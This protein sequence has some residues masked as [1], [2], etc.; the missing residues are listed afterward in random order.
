[1]TMKII[2]EMST[3]NIF[4]PCKTFQRQINRFYNANWNNILPIRH[5]TQG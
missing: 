2:G 1:M 4:R 5:N 3:T